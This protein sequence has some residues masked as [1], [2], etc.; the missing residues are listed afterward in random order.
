[1]HTLDELLEPLL[2]L[3]GRPAPFAGPLRDRLR[4]IVTALDTHLEQHA[5]ET[6][7]DLYLRGQDLIGR[8]RTIQRVPGRD[9]H[10]AVAGELADPAGP[11]R[12]PLWT[13]L[14]DLAGHL[15]VLLHRNGSPRAPGEEHAEREHRLALA[16]LGVVLDLTHPRAPGG[17][18]PLAAPV[19]APVSAV[20][21]PG[22]GRGET[23]DLTGRLR[24]EFDRLYQE[25]EFY[26]GEAEAAP[27]TAEE[28]WIALHVACLRL[29]EAVA[30]SQRKHFAQTF[31]GAAGE[32]VVPPLPA[33]GF[34]GFGEPRERE[35]GRWR[36]P[37]AARMNEILVGM[38]AVAEF[39]PGIYH[40]LNEMAQDARA[41]IRL[42]PVTRHQ[43]RERALTRLREL[44]G[45]LD[46][47]PADVGLA[48]RYLTW[49][50]EVVASFFPLPLPEPGSWWAEQYHRSRSLVLEAVAA[51]GGKADVEILDGQPYDRVLQ[52]RLSGAQMSLPVR[53]GEA[54]RVLWTL[55]L[56]WRFDGVGE[57]GRVIYSVRRR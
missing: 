50:D 15:I 35:R 23:A 5:A 18:P 17:V 3:D 31:A 46:G 38:L 10:G 34:A 28:L 52:K 47:R 39:D 11:L 14:G 32:G 9:L 22:R 20:A 13:A 26:L 54:D 48:I 53:N 16:L 7:V 37:L 24:D 30:A 42:D 45:Q 8:F 25:S 57:P 55:R 40:G 2:G 33:I 12:A 29:P 27:E 1:M 36:S 44:D 4:A 56:P 21:G 41:P 6:T 19:P 51:T 49:V 43:Y